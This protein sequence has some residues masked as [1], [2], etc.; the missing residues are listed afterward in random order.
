MPAGPRAEPLGL[1]LFTLAPRLVPLR[2][3]DA[4]ASALSRRLGLDPSRI[5]ALVRFSAELKRMVGATTS[6]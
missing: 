6:P 2:H 4:R 3:P 5:D 1:G